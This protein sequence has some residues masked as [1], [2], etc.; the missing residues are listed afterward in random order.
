MAEI[1]CETMSLCPACGADCPAWY[2]ESRS[3][4]D[5]CV[6][7]AEHGVAREPVECDTASFRKY[8]E[9]DYSKPPR[10]LVLPV[11]YRCNMSCRYCYSMSNAGLS[12]PA[13]RPIDRL[14]GYIDRYNGNTTLIGGE[15]TVRGDLVELIARAKAVHPCSRI[16]VG[17][18]GQK[19]DEIG[20]V[21]GLKD[22]GLDFV[23][24]SLNDVDYEP[25]PLHHRRKLQALEN[26]R[27]LGMPVWLQRTVD[28]IAQAAS[29]LPLIEQYRR[30]VFEVTLRAVKPMGAQYPSNNVYVSQ[31]VDALG[32]SNCCS[33]G[34]TPFNRRV[35]I[36]RRPVKVCSWINDVRR[37]DPLDSG[38]VI[39]S[40]KLTTFHRGM[41]LDEVLLTRSSSLLRAQ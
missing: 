31:L 39:S 15:P 2:E 21:R 26:C 14:L 37:V 8:Y 4:M 11:T 18:N 6:Q 40:D 35:R 38:Y 20:Y 28:N 3:R 34:T 33:P 12:I 10:H 5:L 19:L 17:T 36:A 1:Y 22:A 32:V 41:K 13:D 7:C 29:L 23:F 25:S 9:M 16:S 27:R 30:V 24:L